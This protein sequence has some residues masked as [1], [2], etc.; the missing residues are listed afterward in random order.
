MRVKR[1][2]VPSEQRTLLGVGT[3]LDRGAA[4][5]QVA[6]TDVRTV[7]EADV[8]GVW[9]RANGAIHG[10]YGAHRARAVPANV[11]L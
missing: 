5:Q 8:V 6:V 7:R 4:R 9:P 3:L 11:F 2:G 10:L 1:I